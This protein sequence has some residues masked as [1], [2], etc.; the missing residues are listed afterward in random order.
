MFAEMILLNEVESFG[1]QDHEILAELWVTLGRHLK[2]SF[3]AVYWRQFYANMNL[4]IFDGTTNQRMSQIEESIN[5]LEILAKAQLNE[6][7]T[8]EAWRSP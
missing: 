7:G 1:R 4:H 3:C 5:R 2:K 8:L 6:Y